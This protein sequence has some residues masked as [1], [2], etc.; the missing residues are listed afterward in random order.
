MGGA[1]NKSAFGGGGSFGNY[2]IK[3]PSVVNH[4][5]PSQIFF[6]SFD[7]VIHK[8]INVLN[9][10]AFRVMDASVNDAP[11]IPDE[12]RNKKR[13]SIFQLVDTRKMDLSKVP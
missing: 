1:P 8:R 4:S 7:D 6:K 10:T 12:Y 11:K 13:G 9:P 2:S 5:D 3:G